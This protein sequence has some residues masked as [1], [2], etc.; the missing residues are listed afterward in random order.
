MADE[1]M[2]AAL[3]ELTS[4][5]AADPVLREKLLAALDDGPAYVRLVREALARRDAAGQN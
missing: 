2:S 1:N 5:V 3:D 4:I